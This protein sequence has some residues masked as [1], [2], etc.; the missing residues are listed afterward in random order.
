[1]QVFGGSELT[2]PA[3]SS[4]QC[5]NVPASG[6][7]G[8]FGKENEQCFDVNIPEQK[9]TNALIGGGKSSQYILEEDLSTAK[10]LRISV[11]SL[12]KP[13]SL[14]QLQQNYDLYSNNNLEINFD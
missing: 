2:V 7:M 4:R 13:T 9:L 12:P 6:I 10:E 1:V 3:S 8:F 11:P 5:V 14:N